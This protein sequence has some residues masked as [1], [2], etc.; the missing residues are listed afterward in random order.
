MKTRN[1]C[2]LFVALLFFHNAFS[3]D[4]TLIKDKIKPFIPD[5]V[6]TQFA[7]NIGFLSV[8][9]GYQFLKNHLYTELLYGYVPASI[10][11][12]KP[13]HTITIKNTFPILSKNFNTIALSPIAGFTTSLET[14]KNSFVILPDKYPKGYY[15][16]NAFHLTFFIGASVH[17]DFVNFKLIKGAD[18]YFELSTVETYLWYAIKSKDVKLNDIVSSAIGINLYLGK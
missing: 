3:Q 7:G 15:L 8:G 18:L 11:K 13:I 5:Y 2:T 6:K 9:V 10:S 1:I 16:P 12:A 4:S 14:G 17:K